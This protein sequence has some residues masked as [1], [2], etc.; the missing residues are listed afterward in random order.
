MFGSSNTQA[1]SSAVS[2]LLFSHGDSFHQETKTGSY[3]FWGDAASFHQWEF[4]TRLHVAAEAGDN[5]VEAVCKV[6]E[7]LRGDAFVVVQEVGLAD[8]WQEPTDHIPSGITTLMHHMKQM[9]FPLT[10]H[11][12]K[13]VFRQ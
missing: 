8:L 10:T 11:G 4:R 6:V 9:V 7:G 13:E 3:V 12:A 1:I 5:Y 2:S